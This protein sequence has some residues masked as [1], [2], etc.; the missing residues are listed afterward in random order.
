MPY[1]NEWLALMHP[2][3]AERII[4]V[5]RSRAFREHQSGYKVEYRIVHSSGEVRWIELRTIISYTM[6]AVLSE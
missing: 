5:F 3:D 6:T 2:E 1:S 4:Q